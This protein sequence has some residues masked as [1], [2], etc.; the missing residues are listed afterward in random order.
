M[1][2]VTA[3]CST[4]ELPRNVRFKREHARVLICN[5]EFRGKRMLTSE[6]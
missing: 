1:F 6:Y 2:N 3:G 4:A 5:L